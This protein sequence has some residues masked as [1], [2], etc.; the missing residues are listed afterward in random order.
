MII[1]GIDISKLKFDVTALLGKD[2]ERHKIFSN[3][4]KGFEELESWFTHLGVQEA[5]ICLEATGSYGEKVSVFLHQ[6]GYKVCVINPTRIKA[7][8]RSEGL[9]T[10]T[11]KVDSG[12][13]A[14]FCKTQCPSVWTPP[15]PEEQHLRDLYRCLQS[16]LEDKTKLS[17]RLESLDDKKISTG[18]WRSLLESVEEKMKEVEGQIKGL[19]ETHKTLGNQLDL[20]KT[21]PGISQKT[22]VAIL[23][24]LPNI[25]VFETAKEVAAFAGL[26][27]CVR[28][29]GTSL[30]G[31]GALSKVGNAQ[32]RKAL[33]MPTLVAKRYNP[34]VQE[35]C[36]RL[37][38]K[39]KP[40]M[41]V[42]AA[43]MRKF[44]HIIFGVLKNNKPF[45][46]SQKEI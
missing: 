13:I 39:G 35:F 38:V 19:L 20:L 41:V 46:F 11:D 8:A 43:A 17:N 15:V 30:K 7:Y 33:Y 45:T 1:V 3:N 22:A 12:V 36:E 27:P 5:H 44:L 14:R 24:E 31:K 34:L 2:K 40:T 42:I 16:L 10:K 37:S 25:Q 18:I 4:K 23:S 28:Q 9:R 32:L 26:T 21:I 6:Q 29:S